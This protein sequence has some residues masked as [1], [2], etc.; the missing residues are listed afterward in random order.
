MIINKGA[1]AIW[2]RTVFSTNGAETIRLPL[3]KKI[4]HR[5]HTF[6]KTELKMDHRSKCTIQNYETHRRPHRGNLGDW[7]DEFL[8]KIPKA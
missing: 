4:Y 7:V 1:K 8:D 3:K 2:W 5:F 6:H